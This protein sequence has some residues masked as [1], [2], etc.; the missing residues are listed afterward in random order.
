MNVAADLSNRSVVRLNAE[1][2]P[3][4]EFER[5]AC[6]DYGIVQT[7]VEASGLDILARAAE[8]DAL[9]VVAESLSAEVI[10]GLGKCRVISRLGAGT[11]KIDHEAATRNGVLITNVPDFCVEEQADHTLALLLGLVRKLPQMDRAMREG[12]W[13]TGRAASRSIRRF[14]G[15]TLGLIGFGHS[16]KAVARR[17]AGFGF[18]I[19]ATRR[20]IVEHDEDAKSLGVEIVDLETVIQESDYLSLHLPLNNSTRHLLTAARLASMKPGAFLINT[21]RGEL[22]D[23]TALAEVLRSGHLGGAGLDTFHEINVHGPESRP[24]HPLLELDN[25]IC[26]PHVAAFSVESSRDVGTVGVEN[27]AAVLSGRWPRIDRVV[28]SEV[29]PRVDLA[30]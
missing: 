6:A 7:C 15:R 29:A 26:T 30:R 2:F 8:C 12:T 4:T 3:V 24:Q 17:A 28:N 11:D 23:E 18:R 13:A 5:A 19:I 25:V 10:Y 21:S 16:A 22:V 14:T 1:S 9:F 27:V 20:R